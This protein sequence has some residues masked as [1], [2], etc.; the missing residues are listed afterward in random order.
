MGGAPKGYDATAYGRDFAV[1]LPF[2]R[3]AAPG[4]M[5]L[6]P[7]VGRAKAECWRASPAGSRARTC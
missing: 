2:V 7:G 3:K 4:L 5:V 6:G 1:F